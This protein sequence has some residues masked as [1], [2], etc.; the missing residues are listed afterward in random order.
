MKKIMSILMAALMAISV[1]AVS[2]VP[3][4]AAD[5]Y[6]SPTATTA[7]N[8]NPVLIVNG[9][10][11]T[12]D[13]TYSQDESDPNKITFTYTGDSNLTGWEFNF[14]ELGLVEGVDY[15]ITYNEDGTVTVKFISDKAIEAWQ[16]GEIRV[17][18]LVEEKPSDEPTTDS[19]TTTKKNDSSK[20]PSTGVSS[21]AI[22]GIAAAGAGIA[23]LAAVKKRDAE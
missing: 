2:V 10:A 23:V 20:S 6:F 5:N 1:F 12:T 4:M 19:K 15:E 18:A 8:K 16:N 9:Q 11:T 7:A 14:E 13:I 17:E 21:S 22:A 3:A